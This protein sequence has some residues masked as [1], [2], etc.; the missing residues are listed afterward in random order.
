MAVAM[1][2]SWFELGSLARLRAKIH[3]LAAHYLLIYVSQIAYTD[4]EKA[5]AI[6]P[7]IW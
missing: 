3:S 2:E 4:Y 5:F 7:D 6:S 1:T